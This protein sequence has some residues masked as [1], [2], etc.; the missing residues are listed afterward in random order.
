MQMRF[1]CSNHN[2]RDFVRKYDFGGSAGVD[3]GAKHEIREGEEGPF[4]HILRF[5]ICVPLLS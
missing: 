2:L 3:S 5:M 1:P 4:N